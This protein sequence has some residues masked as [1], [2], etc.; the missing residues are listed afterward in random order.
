MAVLKDSPTG[1]IKMETYEDKKPQVRGFGPESLQVPSIAEAQ[2]K[3]REENR[4]ETE[5]KAKILNLKEQTRIRCSQA[6]ATQPYCL[7][8]NQCRMWLGD[9]K[10]LHVENLK[11]ST[12]V[13]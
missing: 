1:K 12:G 5:K 6:S 11:K 10:C 8:S 4:R 2:R 13:K 7:E 9:G 3:W